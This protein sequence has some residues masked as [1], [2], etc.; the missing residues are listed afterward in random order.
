MEQMYPQSAPNLSWI[1]TCIKCGLKVRKKLSEAATTLSIE[2]E[3]C[4]TPLY[5]SYL[6]N[7]ALWPKIEK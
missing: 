1:L 7:R 3:V 4:G 2:C 5:T 6:D